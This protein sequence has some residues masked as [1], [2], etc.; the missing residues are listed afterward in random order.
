MNGYRA[1]GCVAACIATLACDRQGE[2]QQESRDLREAQNEV[3]NVTAELESELD[4]AKAEVARLEEK[5]AMARQGV[6]DDV[7]SERKELKESLSEQKRE[8]EGEIQEVKREARRLEQDTAQ[9]ARELERTALPARGEGTTERHE[10]IPVSGT[11]TDAGSDGERSDRT[12]EPA[13]PR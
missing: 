4:E 2:V 13:A 10:L 7:L 5:L 8:V 6:T 1:I 9:A 3:G 12:N 11:S